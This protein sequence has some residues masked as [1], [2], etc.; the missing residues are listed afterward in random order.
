M[1]LHLLLLVLSHRA[2]LAPATRG[3][4]P[5]AIWMLFIVAVCIQLLPFITR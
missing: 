3:V 4:R 2:S 1:L 5:A